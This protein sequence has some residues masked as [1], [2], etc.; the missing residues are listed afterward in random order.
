LSHRRAQAEILALL[1]ECPTEGCGGVAGA[2]PTHR[3]VTLLH[4]S[5]ILLN[6]IVELAAC[7]RERMK[8]G[9]SMTIRPV[10]AIFRAQEGVGDRVRTAGGEAND[11][12]TITPTNC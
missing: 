5:V 2:E 1:V 12:L 7:R 3:I 8:W 9:M 4:S 6:A 11:I 10:W